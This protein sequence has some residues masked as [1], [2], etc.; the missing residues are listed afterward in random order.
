MACFLLPFFIVTMCSGQERNL[1]YTVSRNGTK[2]GSLRLR[3]ITNGKQVT[4]RMSSEVKVSMLLTFNSSIL[5]ES[6]YDNGILTYSR[7]FQKM[8]GNKKTNKK[9]SVAG[10]R[11]IL[12]DDGSIENLGIYPIKYN[13]VCVYTCEPVVAKHIYSDKFEK[14]LPVEKIGL[15]EYKI[16]FPNGSYNLYIY[17]NGICRKIRVNHSM[18]KAEMVLN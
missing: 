17:E 4:Y 3:E 18:Y 9:I 2:I 7:V 11:Y 13:L 14:Y 6:I 8:N 1:N 12:D 15:H 16:S 10:N 5:E